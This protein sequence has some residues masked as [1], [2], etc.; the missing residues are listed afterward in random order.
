MED[1]FDSERAERKTEFAPFANLAM[2]MYEKSKDSSK[3]VAELNKP[4]AIYL[5]GAADAWLIINWLLS[6]QAKMNHGAVSVDELV[7]S[8]APAMLAMLEG[9]VATA[10]TLYDQLNCEIDAA[11]GQSFKGP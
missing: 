10:K 5:K 3:Q 6:N 11:S 2:A 4:M 9:A 1:S 8:I 7:P